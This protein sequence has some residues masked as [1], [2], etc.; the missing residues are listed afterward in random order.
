M[1]ANVGDKLR[2]HGRTVGVHDRVGE[3]VEVLGANGEP[4]YR[5][6]FEDGH[7]SLMA[8]GPDSEIQHPSRRAA[9]P[10]GGSPH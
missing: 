4:P 10:G 6:R 5:V 3:V 7:E 1:H 8:P 2:L 9:E